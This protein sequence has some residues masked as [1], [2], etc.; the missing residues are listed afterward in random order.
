[1][2]IQTIPLSK[3]APCP[4]NVRKTG[5]KT[6]IEGLA[7]SIVAHGL[8]QNLQVRPAADE[9]FEVVAGGRRFDALKLLAKQ[10]KIA[11]DYPVPCDVRESADA[12]EIS[13][14]E[15]EMRE[16]MHPADQFEAFKKLAEEGKGEEEIAAHFGVTPQA[17]RQRLKLAVVSPKLIAAYRKGDMT[18]DCLMA[19]T[20]SDDHKQQEKVWAGLPDYARERP[21][22]IRNLL[23]EK[24]AAADSRLALFVGIEAYAGAGGAVLRD[25][26][27][28]GN[29]WLTDPALLDRLAAAKL[30]QAAE[31]V[32]GE[33]W[34]W[35]EIM[36]D[37][38]WEATKGYGHAEA[39]RL[40]PNAGQQQEIET[41]TAEGNAIIDQHGEEPEDEDASNRLWD[42]QQ[43]I[44]SLSEGDES[45]PDQ[46][47]ANAG[48]VIGIDHDGALDI[49]RGLIRPEDK[50][51]ARKTGN[52]RKDTASGTGKKDGPPPL[53]A[54]LVENLTAHRTAGLQAM[55][56]GNP[57]VALVAVV[58]A[59]ALY[60]LYEP[61]SGS[62]V[63]VD[64][65]M[66]YLTP[67]AEGIDDSAA[68]K[69]F[70]ATIKAATKGMPK[71]PEKLWAWLLGQDQKSLLAILAVCAA[72]SVDA[73]VKRHGA[74]DH[75]A[76]AGEL[77]EALKLDM[78]GYWQPTAEGYF[79]RVSK[80]LILE[81]VREGIGKPAADN[82]AALKKDAMAKRAE[83]LLAGKGWLPAILR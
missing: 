18:L 43:R 33:G 39:D 77:A 76:H 79:G 63:K 9:I 81:A 30:E 74:A 44:V 58:H 36:P 71:Q 32:R 29:A 50:A 23:T 8:L 19:F 51:A 60:C 65:K 64:A 69:R 20:V 28:D 37:L 24:H 34:K 16:A 25:L 13:L 59:L 12:T 1:M 53:P 17:V 22:H 10:K 75:A 14:A 83:A 42:I 5:R 49:R 3:L 11:P 46:A 67:S 38:S 35:V 82:I 31:A 7:A 70:G 26:F 6:G 27:D 66:A 47:K 68:C 80:G 45:W 52:T 41:L 15:N 4:A 55:L 78:A 62:C 61:M 21:G 48:A 40:P 57:K 56:A 54:A 2:H 73:V 72:S